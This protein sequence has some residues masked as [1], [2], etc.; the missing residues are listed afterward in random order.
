MQYFVLASDY[1]GTVAKHGKIEPGT[2]K[3][4]ERCLDSGRKLVLVTGRELP[5]LIE[6][7]PAISL[8]EWVVAENGGL[9]YR[10]A[11]REVRPLAAPP[12]PEFVR[13]LRDRGVAPCSKGEVI[14][15]TWEPHEEMVLATIRDLGL[16]LQVIFNKGAVMILPSGI[17]KAT[18]LAKALAEMEIS[19]HNVVA[20]GDAE[21]DH[22]LLASCGASVAVAN[23]TESLKKEA[24][25]V[26]SKENGAGV[27]ELIEQLLKDDLANLRA[28][29]VLLRDAT[30]ESP[31]PLNRGG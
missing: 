9:L 12:P 26:L 23:A 25:L 16:E 27:G 11:T 2:V 15:S 14:V 19:P 17:N 13:T 30:S 18:G 1:D 31:P 3:A 8:F 10:P 7:C 24:D 4:L 5:E 20:V 28:R 6:I 21:N 22:A 29:A